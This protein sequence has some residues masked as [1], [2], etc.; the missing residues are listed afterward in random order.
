MKTVGVKKRSN[1]L[2]AAVILA[3]QLHRHLN[4][5]ISCQTHMVW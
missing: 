4:E 1:T 5:I 3:A 2:D